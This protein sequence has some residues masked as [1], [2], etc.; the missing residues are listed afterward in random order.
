MKLK[1]TEKL[2]ITPETD[3]KVITK[4]YV[5]E[6]KIH[7]FCQTCN[8]SY[9]GILR[10]L[11]N[12]PKLICKQCHIDQTKQLRYGNKKYNNSAQNKI[13]NL[14]KYGVESWA[15]TDEGRKKLSEISKNI[16]SEI[17]KC[18]GEKIK[19]RSIEAKRQTQE[20][21]KQTIIKK[22]GSIEA[23]K[24]HRLKQYEETC[25]T[26]Y[27]VNNAGALNAEKEYKAWSKYYYDERYFDSGWELAY[28]IWLKDNNIKFEYHNKTFFEY[29]DK[30]GKLHRYYPDFYVNEEYHEIKSGLYWDYD[31]QLLKGP[32]NN[33][34]IE[35]TNCLKEHNVKIISMKEI[36]PI[37]NYVKAKYGTKYLKSFKCQNKT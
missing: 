14:K 5:R 18:V 34:N 30:N 1:T 12:N 15:Q 3:I 8:R 20:K 11:I 27:N 21:K 33:Y 17:R 23:Y 10:Y 2:E 4:L 37:L 16:D 24:K 36:Q 6:T 13:T 31:K 28:Y 25:R 19:N 35:K 26:K 29:N 7:F 32:K 9:N 22:Y